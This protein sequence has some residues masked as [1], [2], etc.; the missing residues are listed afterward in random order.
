M[1]FRKIAVVTA[2]TEDHRKLSMMEDMKKTS[3]GCRKK[4]GIGTH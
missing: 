3:E 1:N 2:W 4:D